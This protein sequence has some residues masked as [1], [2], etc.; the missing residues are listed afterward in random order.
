LFPSLQSDGYGKGMVQLALLRLAQPAD[1]IGQ[2][3]LGDAHE[4]IAMNGA[5]V[6]QAL[7]DADGNLRR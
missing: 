6:L 2:Q 7:T 3:R 5:V 1:E 4:L